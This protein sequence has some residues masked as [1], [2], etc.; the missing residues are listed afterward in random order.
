MDTFTTRFSEPTFDY[1]MQ[2]G[3][4]ILFLR[5]L[6][7]KPKLDQ[8]LKETCSSIFAPGPSTV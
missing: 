6:F 8:E 4:K 7:N 5:G 3:L 2:F 1:G